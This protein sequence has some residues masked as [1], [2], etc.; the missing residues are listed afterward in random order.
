MRKTMAALFTG[1]LLATTGCGGATLE[2]FRA[3]APSAQG[4]EVQMRSA[5]AQGLIGAPAVMPGV[6]AAS[7]LIVNTP[8][9]LVL[10]TVAAVVAT[11]PTRESS[12]E[13]VWG[14]HSKP[15]WLAEYQ[16]TMTKTA[17][18]FEYS[19][20]ARSKLTPHGDFVS[21]MSGLHVS[22][23]PQTT[24]DFV[25]DWVALAGIGALSGS[26][27][28]VQVAYSRNEHRDV[29]LDIKFLEG[30]AAGGTVRT[31]GRYGFAQVQGGEGHLEFVVDTNYDLHTL[32][33]E[34][35]SVNSR[36]QWNGAGRA[37]VI[38]SGGDLEAPFRFT[39]CW[40]QALARAYYGDT[41]SLFPA[42]GSQSDCAYAQA[43]FSSL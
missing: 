22:G 42:E 1:A 18:G 31:N 4:I 35:L 34:R 41:L 9:A 20:S 16:L 7:A 5:S 2:D 23:W 33:P 8:V 26:A 37:D 19:V 15:L 6:T 40:D 10:E 39:E 11:T 17:K 29:T 32:A 43:A 38:G 13:V 25:I 14:P 12:V 28:Q 30:S 21:V 24:G 3:A 36:W 27:G